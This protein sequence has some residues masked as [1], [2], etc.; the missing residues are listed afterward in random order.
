MGTAS[1]IAFID[2]QSYRC[3]S[4]AIS[5]AGWRRSFTMRLYLHIFVINAKQ[6]FDKHGFWLAIF[7]YVIFK[8]YG[9]QL[10]ALRANEFS[11]ST[12][13]LTSSPALIRLMLREFSCHASAAFS[14]ANGW[15][16]ALDYYLFDA[17]S[18][19]CYCTH[20]TPLSLHKRALLAAWERSISWHDICWAY[21]SLLSGWLI[22]SHLFFVFI[23]WG[24]A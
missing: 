16:T 15:R 24:K 13:T 9:G 17:S 14:G 19:A 6:R 21:C 12:R 23:Y 22:F 7:E 10:H 8:I 2:S 1:G 20:L 11:R 5:L 18:L 4:K 3:A